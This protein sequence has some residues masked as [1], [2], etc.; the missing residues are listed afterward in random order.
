MRTPIAIRDALP[1]ELEA[2]GQLMVGVYARLEGFPSPDEQ[3]KYYELLAD[4]GRFTRQPDARILVAVKGDELMGGVV[5]FSDM[6]SYG[7]GGTATHEKNAA[8]FRFLAVAPAARGMGVGNALIDE[9]IG[10]ARIAKRSRVVIHT[11]SAMKIAWGMYE[12]LG[13]ARAPDLDFRQGELP[14]FGFRLELS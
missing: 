6:A 12:R 14:V 4:I 3:P 1:G 13:F 2:L 10:L 9:C 8:G 5:Y 11:T 7:A